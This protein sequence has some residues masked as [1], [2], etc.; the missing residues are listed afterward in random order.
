MVVNTMTTV[1]QSSY[2]WVIVAAADHR[3]R[4]EPRETAF[5]K[6]PGLIGLRER[7]V[8]LAI[9]G[10]SDLRLLGG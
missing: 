5:T 2:C 1:P 6:A 9:I 10:S 3:I 7:V 4:L 8:N